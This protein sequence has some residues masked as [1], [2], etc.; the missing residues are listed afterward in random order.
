MNPTRRP[1][2]RAAGSEAGGAW[3]GLEEAVRPWFE[4]IGPEDRRRLRELLWWDMTSEYDARF[5]SE[6]LE[7]LGLELS[8]EF[9]RIHRLWE[10][11]EEAHY[12]VAR[13]VREALFGWTAEERRAFAARR[14]D[15]SPLAH[16]FA[17]EFSI[18]VL[19]AYDELCTVQG[20]RA[21]LPLYELL[22]PD[23]A[24]FVRRT[25]ADEALHY[26]RALELIRTRHRHRLSELPALLARIRAAESVPY[27]NTFVMDHEE[28]VY[29]EAVA[30]RAARVLLDQ[31]ARG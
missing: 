28:E 6:Y 12:R 20:Y 11:E 9:L 26:R 21:N 24:A 22:G 8:D 13:R 23:Y 29:T 15:F 31:A 25:I 1:P 18:A 27:G 5:L 17:D 7:G 30:E 14:P 10:A 3:D 4:K 16:L 19:I 2:R